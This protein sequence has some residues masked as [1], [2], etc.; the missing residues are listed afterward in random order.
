[1]EHRPALIEY[2]AGFVGSRAQAED[3][4]QEAWVRLDAAVQKRPIHEPLAYLYRIVRNLAIDERS[5]AARERRVFVDPDS[6]EAAASAQF[7]GPTPEGVAHYKD[8]LRQLLQAMEALPER[9]RIAFQMHR[10]GGYKL[11]EIAEHL[12]ISV[13]LAHA[14]VVDGLEHCKQRLRWVGPGKIL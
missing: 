3:V 12:G 6:G 5:A 7:T 13:P 8:E 4:V 2:A 1:M 9:T 10:L 14:L 11:R